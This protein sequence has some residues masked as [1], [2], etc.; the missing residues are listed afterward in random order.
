MNYNH[1]LYILFYLSF[2]CALYLPYVYMFDLEQI[3]PLT[4]YSQSFE[5]VT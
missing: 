1:F 3:K 2:K 5:Y 4:D